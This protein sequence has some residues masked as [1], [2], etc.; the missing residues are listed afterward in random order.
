MRYRP[1]F[2]LSRRNLLS[3]TGTTL[4]LGLAQTG[5]ADEK[6][7]TPLADV[8]VAV[9]GAGLSGLVAA[10]SLAAAGHSVLVLEARERVGGRTLNQRAYGDR[11]VDGGAQW[12]GGSQTA[13]MEL[14]QE[15]GAALIP[16]EYDGE[17]AALIDGKRY[18]FAADTPPGEATLALQRELERLARDV[19]LDAPWNAGDAKALDAI[20][21]QDWLARQTTDAE[22]LEA[23]ATTLASTLNARPEE[24]S[25]LWFLFYLHSSGGFAALDS[26]AQQYR[27]E[28]GA[29]SLSLGLARQLGGRVLLGLPVQRISGIDSPEVRLHT[30]AGVIH[31]R[32]AI[33]AMMPAD[34]TRIRFSPALP[35]ARRMLQKGW[36]ASSSMKVHV[37][38]RQ[39]FWR[40]QGLSGIG[41]IDS[42]LVQFTFDSTPPDQSSGILLAFVDPLLA[43]TSAARRRS[44]VLAELARLFGEQAR[45]PLTY[46]E[47]DWSRDSW[48]AGCVSP[49][50]PGLLSRYGHSLR[51]PVGRLHWAGSETSDI[52]CG[53]LEGAVRAGLRA[54]QEVASTLG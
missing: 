37:V 44:Q 45:Q 12:V 39:P 38:Y 48:S 53:Y 18:T 2:T 29:Q 33:L 19:P 1:P 14:A 13:V 41:F 26:E 47:Q 6:A 54:A 32:R 10:R 31:A 5:Q 27:L 11:P 28:G 36:G 43:R 24:V 25:L 17:M 20:S 22:A 50:P 52:C 40:E 23:V 51:E 7:A 35:R 9:I 34:A 15:L 8:D 3:L 42:G 4:L 49:Q 30:E 16:Q 46:V 21:V